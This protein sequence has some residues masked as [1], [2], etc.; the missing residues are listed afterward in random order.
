M[1]SYIGSVPGQKRDYYFRAESYFREQTE[2]A[3]ANRFLWQHC[4]KESEIS[5]TAV[6]QQRYRVLR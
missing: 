1:K 3:E 5:E 4:L 6:G 2:C